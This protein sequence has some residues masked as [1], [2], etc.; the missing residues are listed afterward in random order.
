[1]KYLLQET[2]TFSQE[3][4]TETLDYLAYIER[5]LPQIQNSREVR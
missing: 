3:Q 1:M 5:N 2:N 4:M